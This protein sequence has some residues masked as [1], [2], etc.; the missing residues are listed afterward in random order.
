M[1]KVR[2]GEL[3]AGL[4]DRL[5]SDHAHGLAGIHQHAP[6]QIA[7]IAL[8]T[9]AIPGFADE[10]RTHPHLVDTQAVDVLHGRFVEQGAGF[11]ERFL[12]F[13]VDD[14]AGGHATE[15]AVTQGLDHL[16]ALDERLH[17][18]TVGG[19]AIVFGDHQILGDVDQTAREVARVRGFECG[20]GQALARAVRGDEVLE[21]VQTLAEVGG[22]G[23]FD[24][25]AIG[26]GHQ[27][28][29]AGE[30]TDL[31]GRA[32]R[33]RIG[34]HVDGVE[35]LLR[36]GFALAVDHLL[37]RKL[38]HHGLADQVARAAPDV[39]HLVVAL[40]LRDQTRGVLLLDF[41]D[42]GLGRFQDALLLRRH[43]HV[44]DSDRDA[45]ARGQPEAV[46]HE[47]VGKDDRVTQAAAPE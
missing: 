41:L 15:D 17:G 32:A 38:L 25:R 9:Q 39:D 22:D 35:R 11:V 27:A 7:A 5:R 37:G 29:H 20:V 36:Y 18:H 26:L 44:V 19:A 46:L 2:M 3:R 4:A 23:R 21:Y 43:Q 14:I 24:D 30:L 8:G 40:A 45:G 6:A 1:W 10:G 42:L 47:L 12:R 33:A 13:R 34:H 16:A 31:G 28:A